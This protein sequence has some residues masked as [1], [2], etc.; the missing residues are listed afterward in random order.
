MAEITGCPNLHLGEIACRLMN[1][2]EFS[3][4]RTQRFA[5]SGA[6]CVANHCAERCAHRASLELDRALDRLAAV[7]DFSATRSVVGP[8]TSP[9]TWAIA[10]ATASRRSATMMPA[11]GR[12]QGRAEISYGA[13]SPSRQGPAGGNGGEGRHDDRQGHRANASLPPRRVLPA[14]VSCAF[15]PISG[16]TTCGG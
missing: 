4:R 8:A 1:R 16:R 2:L 11:A 5:F 15:K 13:P 12:R 7:P 10:P 3:R 14:I 9:R 6:F